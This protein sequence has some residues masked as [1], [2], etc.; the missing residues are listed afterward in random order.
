M[1]IITKVSIALNLILIALLIIIIAFPKPTL[2][3]SKTAFYETF[4]SPHFI[5][6]NDLYYLGAWGP[7]ATLHKFRVDGDTITQVESHY[8]EEDEVTTYIPKLIES[9]RSDDEGRVHRA[10]RFL[11][12]VFRLA[13][14]DGYHARGDDHKGTPFEKG[15]YPDA[16]YDEWKSWW[17]REGEDFFTS[18]PPNYFKIYLRR[19][20]HS[21]QKFRR[22]LSGKP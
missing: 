13:W 1:N 10:R 14:P 5:E 19:T 8:Y 6:G 15:K 3:L 2:I 22:N 7:G 16:G 17:E 9:L 21:L 18:P 4:G 12:T 11:T 20:I